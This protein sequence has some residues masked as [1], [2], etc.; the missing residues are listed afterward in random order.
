M[1]YNVKLKSLIKFTNLLVK[2]GKKAKAASFFLKTLFILKKKTKKNPIN[3]L[4]SAIKNLTPGVSTRKTVVAGR[5]YHLP[6]AITTNKALYFGCNWLQDSALNSKEG[7]KTLNLSEKI[8]SE[9]LKVLRKKGNAIL[10][11]KQ[12]NKSVSDNRPFLRFVKRKRS[13]RLP[14]KV[15]L[16]KRKILYLKKRKKKIISKKEESFDFKLDSRI[17]LKKRHLYDTK[18][19]EKIQSKLDRR[20]SK[21]DKKR[22]LELKIK[23]GDKIQSKLDRRFSKLDKKRDLELKIKNGNKNKKINKKN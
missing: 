7:G 14:R 12:H 23:N 13:L 11:L 18:L 17:R 19:E 15:F 4:Y 3:S 5:L 10:M 9:A 20:F 8:V 6:C 21:L 16:R 22:D 2:K 1:I